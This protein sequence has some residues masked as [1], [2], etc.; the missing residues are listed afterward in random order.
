MINLFETHS[1]FCNNHGV[2]HRYIH[3]E[4]YQEDNY[5]TINECIL[6]WDEEVL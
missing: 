3:I 4:G 1:D 5:T 6:D 2:F